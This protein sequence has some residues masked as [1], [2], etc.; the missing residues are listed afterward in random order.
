MIWLTDTSQ[1]IST[2]FE[3]SL[4]NDGCLIVNFHQLP[5]RY[6]YI[7]YSPHSE[8]DYMMVFTGMWDHSWV[9]ALIVRTTNGIKMIDDEWIP[10]TECCNGSNCG[11]YSNE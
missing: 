8:S 10:S 4:L 11:P 5:D 3:K 1:S 6:A 2:I 7:A 9:D